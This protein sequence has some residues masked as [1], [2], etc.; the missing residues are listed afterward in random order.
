MNIVEA[1]NEIKKTVQ[2]YLL[3]DSDNNYTIPNVRQRPIFLIGPPGIGKTA[4]ISQISSEMDIGMVSYTITHHTRQSAIGLPFIIEKTY[5]NKSY[6]VTEYTLS[7]IVATVHNIIKEQNKKEGIL[8][9]DEINCVS[10]SL[11]PA[12]LDLLQNK[13]FGPHS[14][15]EGW[16]LVSAG[17]PVEFNRSAREFDMVTL[18]RVKKIEVDSDYEVWKKY[19]YQ[20]LFSEDILSFLSIREHTLFQVE[21]TPTGLIFSTPRAWEDLSVAIKSYEKLKFEV[22]YNMIAQYIQHPDIAREFYRYY[23]LYKKYKNDYD[24]HS[25]LKGQ[26]NQD[27]KRFK[28]AAFDEKLAVIEVML[29]VINENA[30]DVYDNHQNKQY[31]KNLITTL[32]STSM[33]NILLSKITQLETQISSLSRH[34]TRLTVLRSRLKHLKALS[35]L[36]KEEVKEYYHEFE[37][38]LS[39]STDYV[40]DSIQNALAFVKTC[41]GEGQE[42]VAMLVNMLA[43]AHILHF[44]TLRNIPDF[45][46]FNKSLLID[47]QSKEILEEIESLHPK[48]KKINQAL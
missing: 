7:E 2:M 36:S 20:G 42:L 19:A 22:D 10:E 38:K 37:K 6:S 35:L 14:I 15:P 43:S 8:F 45:Y 4:I 47:K 5:E 34:D 24:V 46:R 44:L 9:I 27:I 17:N 41:F 1:K 33:S 16:I 40:G 39:K 28:N 31:L 11:A 32:L 29:S 23:L 13:K 3:K 30:K 12:M 48:N 21:K 18:D 26:F 25:I